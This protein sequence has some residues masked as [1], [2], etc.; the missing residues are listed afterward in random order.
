[1]AVS[2]QKRKGDSTI[3]VERRIRPKS[4]GGTPGRVSSPQLQGNVPQ[5]QDGNTAGA[6]A[7]DG[8]HGY[9]SAVQAP[10][11]PTPEPE[12]PRQK[13]PGANARSAIQPARSIDSTKPAPA[14]LRNVRMPSGAIIPWDVS[15]ERLAAEMQAYTLQ[16][17]GKTLAANEAAR[18][19]PVSSS[20]APPITPTKFRPKKPVMRYAERH[21]E[22]KVDTAMD[23]DE[24]YIEE[25]MD[26]DSEYIIETYIRMPAEAM[27]DGGEQN[28][29]LLVLDSQPDI[30]EFYREEE[31]S[32][33]E[34]DDEEEDENGKPCPTPFARAIAHSMTAENHY[35]VDYPDEEVDSDDEFGRNAYN[36]RNHNASD[37]EEFDEDDATFSDDENENTRYPWMRKP[38]KKVASTAVDD[39]A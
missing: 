10:L 24:E 36:Y 26:D 12:K 27:Q 4:A 23:V 29:G 13:R 25:V 1:M 30:E 38:V 35:T 2:N 34:E 39:N 19:V 21:P 20:R 18:P 33:E 7:L 6:Q 28:I 17:I 31:D 8:G 32:E 5:G 37:L 14:P 9:G 22:D 3:F 11:T 16:E 15:S